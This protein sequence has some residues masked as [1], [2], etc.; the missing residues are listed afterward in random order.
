MTESF[1][2]FDNKYYRQQNGA[3][4]SSSLGAKLILISFFLYVIEETMWIKKWL[5]EYRPVTYK[6]YGNETF[7]VSQNIV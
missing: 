5:Y 4:V 7:L 1:I 6:K 3:A 2:L